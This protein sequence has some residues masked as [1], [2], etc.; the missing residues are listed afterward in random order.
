MGRSAVCGLPA[1]LRGMLEELASADAAASQRWILALLQ[2]H[3]PGVVATLWR[4]LGREQDVLDAYQNV[5]CQLAARGPD[6]V[7]R[8]R[9]A[10]FYRSAI[11]AGIEL[12]R[13]RR[14]DQNALGRLAERRVVSDAPPVDGGANLEH[15]R[16]IEQARAAVLALPP[17][18]R[19]VI[20]LRD[21]AGF[22]YS[23]VAKMLN[24]TAATARVYRRQAIVRLAA[25]LAKEDTR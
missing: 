18:L 3:G 9:G 1:S 24:I 12:I 14:R 8:N 6:A 4:M 16:V 17:Y 25:R 20:L 19:D 23:R 5:V 13:R 11:N 22:N 10:Y 2:E 21:M 7:G 15:L